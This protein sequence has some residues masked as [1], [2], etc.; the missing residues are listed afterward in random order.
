MNMTGPLLQLSIAGTETAIGAARPEA[1]GKFLF[2]NDRKLHIRG[3]SYGAFRPDAEGREYQDRA[4][5]DRDFAMMAEHGFNAVRIPHTMPPAFLLDIAERYGLRVMVGLSAEQYVGYLIDRDDAP[6]V[7][8]MV[9]EKAKTV[10][11]H[12]A[13]LCYGIG[14]EIPSSIARWIGRRPLERYL[15]RLYEAVKS[16]DPDGLVTYVNYPSTE[17]LHLP[18]LDLVSF[19]VYL[20]TRE[21]LEQ[22][23]PRLH[24]IAGDRPLLLAE[25]GLDSLRN[26]EMAQ[27]RSLEWQLEASS[28]A[29]CVGSFIFS[30]TDE[31]WRGGAAVDDWKFGLTT[32]DRRPKPALIAVS[33]TFARLDQARRRR[34][35]RV[36]IVVCTYNGS[37]T[38]RECLAGALGLDYPNYEV[39]VVDDGSTDQT[40]AIASEL[41]VRLIRTP[42]QGLSSA[43]NT[44]LAAATGEIVAY[45][46][47]DAYPDPHW[48]D[49]IVSVFEREDVA[50]VGGPNLPP[51]GD[52]WIAECVADAPGGPAHVLL[53]DRLAEHIPGCNMAFRR[54]RLQAIGGFD[55]VFRKAGDDVDV[56]WRVLDQGW[57]IGFHA[58]AQVWHRRR[59]SIRAY[60]RQQS[61][62]GE[63]EALLERKWPEKYNSLGHV[64]WGG[65]VYHRGITLPLPLKRLRIY[66]G[67]WGSAPFQ[68]I[69]QPAPGLLLSLPLLPEWY[70]LALFLVVVSLLGVSWR[71]LALAAPFA[72]LALILPVVQAVHSARRATKARLIR[73]T[74]RRQLAVT[75]LLHLLHPAARLWGRFRHGLTPW[76][77]PRP[78]STSWPTRFT[79]AHWSSAW[80]EPERWLVD[81]E[82]QLR[83]ERVAVQ[84]GGDFDAW[85]FEIRTAP[86]GA[87]RCLMAFE[88]HG[89]GTQLIRLRGWP[90]PKWRYLA[91]TLLIGAL[92][93]GAAWAREPIPAG[94]L[95][96]TAGTLGLLHWRALRAAMGILRQ[97]ADALFAAP[98][99]EQVLEIQ[100]D[101][102]DD[103]VR[104]SSPITAAVQS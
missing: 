45:L 76:R 58:A 75:A 48:L 12:P 62:Y 89:S 5:L 7:E 96:L 103:D 88:D 29:G 8:R 14:N 65:R 36:S 57:R 70:L 82:E 46:D 42:N 19:N 9:V 87:A 28:E 59:G 43:R 22:Y 56:C 77:H 35:P 20:E 25:L 53:S 31:W 44:G 49:Y 41:P 2:A 21:A 10:A 3:V 17:Y 24:S 80:R 63:A 1:R 72:V 69:H 64:A 74:R 79:R 93:V 60:W 4:I 47:D 39:I 90:R 101:P 51:P 85:D 73:R 50:A 94:V 26:G 97:R 32:A 95:A 37:R 6:D 99:D 83:S 18:F 16:C 67:V 55:P 23:L 27:A 104:E 68:S 71:P 91:V 78:R 86:F 34:A 61:G 38:L 15:C 33:R 30:W 84:R 11:G 66:H 81:L 52:G 40:A 100:S 54:S 102:L 98:Q 92:A 13:L